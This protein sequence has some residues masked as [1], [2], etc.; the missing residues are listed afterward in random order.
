MGE[1]A[2]HPQLGNVKIGTCEEMY[3]LRHGQRHDV[4]PVAGNVDPSG[5]DRFGLRFRFPWPTE[6]GTLPGQFADPMKSL[7]IPGLVAPE[8]VEHHA[9]QFRC[10]AGYLL[11]LPCPETLPVDGNGV[12]RYHDARL[13]KNGYR[14]AVHLVQQ[15][16]APDGTLMAIMQCGTC[17]AKWRLP[18]WDDAE[19]VVV[20]LRVQA[21]NR[22]RCSAGSPEFWHQ[23]ADRVA[24]GYGR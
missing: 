24:A 5:P 13:M 10:D 2:R 7:H 21:D 17:G 22:E 19:P 15:K 1:Y 20:A 4:A 16:P 18:T 12:T 3:Y 9:V 6:D 23:V 11:S 14:G 8:G